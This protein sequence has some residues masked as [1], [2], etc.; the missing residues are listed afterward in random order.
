VEPAIGVG[1]GHEPAAVFVVL[2]APGVILLMGLPIVVVVDE[3]VA[4]V[5]GRV[6][7][8]E[9][10]LAGVGLLEELQ[11]V[12]IVALDVEVPRRIPVD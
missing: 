3:V 8:D 4:R 5:V 11:R 2:A 6:Y 10:H 7:V 9:L 1:I 12:E